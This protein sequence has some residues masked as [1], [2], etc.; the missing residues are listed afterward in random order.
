MTQTKTKVLGGDKMIYVYV[1]CWRTKLAVQSACN[2]IQ[3]AKTDAYTT[4]WRRMH[5]NTISGSCTNEWQR[6]LRGRIYL[7]VTGI[8]IA[9]SKD[10]VS[11]VLIENNIASSHVQHTKLPSSFILSSKTI[12]HLHT[13]YAKHTHTHTHTHATWESCHFQ[14]RLNSK[15]PK[16]KTNVPQ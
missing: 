6:K 8:S 7:C 15:L 12:H 2:T 11:V 14:L 4:H 3:Q 5:I 1:H 9:F 13:K 10:K 16:R